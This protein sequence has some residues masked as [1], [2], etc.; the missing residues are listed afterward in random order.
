MLVANAGVVEAQTFDHLRLG[1]AG[2]RVVND[3]GEIETVFGYGRGPGMV[4]IGETVSASIARSAEF[5]GLAI[6]PR[7]RF[8]STSRFI[9]NIDATPLKVV[10][11]AVTFTLH[12][13]RTNDGGRSWSEFPDKEL[14][15]RPGESLPVDLVDLPAV[16]DCDLAK[17]SIR[18]MVDYAPDTEYDRRVVASELWLIQKPASGLQQSELVSVRG[19]YHRPIPFYFST[20]TDRGVS[21]DFYGQI[22]IHPR[23]GFSDVE[24][25]TYSRLLEGGREIQTMSLNIPGRPGVFGARKAESTIQMKPGEV[26]SVELPRLGENTSGAFAG[27]SF[28][29]TIRTRQIR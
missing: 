9:W 13:R 4:A 26:I 1:I 2:L 5:C 12:W 20:L 3:G 8:D 7:G 28:S 19:Q 6:G 23:D 21:L 27:A 14:T 17:V 11:D 24:I 18:V 22:A 29:I 16:P 15:L 25:T 10:Q